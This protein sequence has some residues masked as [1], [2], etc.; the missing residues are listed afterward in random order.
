MLETGDVGAGDPVEVG[1]RP[2]HGIPAH[3]VTVGS[4]FRACPTHEDRPFEL[5][6]A[7]AHLPLRTRAKVT[8]GIEERLAAAQG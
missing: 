7:V 5:A 4:A 1:H 3:G 8:A 2:D 6:L